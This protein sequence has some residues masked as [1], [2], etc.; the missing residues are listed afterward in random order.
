MASTWKVV[1]TDSEKV[2]DVGQLFQTL[3]AITTAATQRKPGAKWL[4][5]ERRDP[6]HPLVKQAGGRPVRLLIEEGTLPYVRATLARV[7]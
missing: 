7:R 2:L 6:E 1:W 4:F 5:S 3:A